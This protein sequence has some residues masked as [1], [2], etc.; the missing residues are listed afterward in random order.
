MY[1]MIEPARE[2]DLQTVERLSPITY[3]RVPKGYVQIYP[4]H[5]EAPS[6]VEGEEYHIQILTNDAPIA[7]A[8]FTIRNGRA[9]E[10]R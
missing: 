10:D 1:W 3:G 7:Q 5:G 4:E 9:V 6:L 8:F 2:A